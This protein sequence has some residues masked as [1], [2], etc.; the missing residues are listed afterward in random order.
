MERLIASEMCPVHSFSFSCS[1]E[2]NKARVHTHVHTRTH[3]H[4]HQFTVVLGSREDSF[5]EVGLS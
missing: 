4:T 5:A 3:A 2:T 1:K